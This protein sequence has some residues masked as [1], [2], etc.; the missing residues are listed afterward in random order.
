VREPPEEKGRPQKKI[1]KQLKIEQIPYQQQ[2]PYFKPIEKG[3]FE[4]EQ[5]KVDRDDED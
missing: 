2:I 5:A 1:I 3:P 4:K